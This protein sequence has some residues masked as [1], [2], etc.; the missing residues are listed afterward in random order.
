MSLL[1]STFPVIYSTD[2]D[3]A[4]MAAARVSAGRAVVFNKENYYTNCDA[5]PS[6]CAGDAG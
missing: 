1:G 2:N 6:Q 4:I 5:D 3:H